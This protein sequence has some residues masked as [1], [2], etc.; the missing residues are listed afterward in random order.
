M[1]F[2]DFRCMDAGPSGIAQNGRGRLTQLLEL[3]NFIRRLFV[4]GGCYMN[5]VP[6]IILSTISLYGVG[7]NCHWVLYIMQP[8]WPRWCR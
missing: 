2:P 5:Y 4:F 3:G 6:T 7:M 8:T 1:P